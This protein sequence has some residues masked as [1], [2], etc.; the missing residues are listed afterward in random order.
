MLVKDLPTDEQT[1]LR[2]L[3]KD[4]SSLYS[5]LSEEYKAEWNLECQKKTY[6]ECPKIVEHVEES[7][8]AL[9]IFDKCQIIPVEPDYYDWELQQRA[10]RVNAP[11]KEHMCKSVILENTRCTHEDISE[12]YVAPVNTQKL[13]N[14]CRNL[15]NKEIS[16]KYYNFRL[17]DP[18]V[19]LQLT[20]FEKGGVSP[21][22]MKQPIP[23]ILAESVIKL[24]PSVIYLGAGHIDWKLGIPIDT[25]IKST[26][27]FI[28]DLD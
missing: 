24:K 1:A 22:G 7:L 13:L 5:A 15:K 28:T 6:T 23:I 17:A 21:F 25:F 4:I 27:C 14:Y 12:K 8:K 19:S 10:F 11:S 9:D 16:K 26:N 18:E 20:G 2:N 3:Q